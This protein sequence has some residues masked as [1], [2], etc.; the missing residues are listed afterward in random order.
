M[1]VPKSPSDNLESF[2][3][4]QMYICHRSIQ[5]ESSSCGL[6]YVLDPGFTERARWFELNVCCCKFLVVLIGILLLFLSGIRL[7][8]VT[9]S[10]TTVTLKELSYRS[11][12]QER[13]RLASAPSH[14]AAPPT[15]WEWS[16]VYWTTVTSPEATLHQWRLKVL[17]F[18]NETGLVSTWQ[19]SPG[20]FLHIWHLG[21]TAALPLTFWS[22]PVV[23]INLWVSM[24]KMST[25]AWKAG[26]TRLGLERCVRPL[27]LKTVGVRVSAATGKSR[28]RKGEEATI[29]KIN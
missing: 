27:W 21:T 7:H 10:S 2:G 5:P 22:T 24:L 23:G 15:C 17:L 25:W 28:S 9:F 19:P 13:A 12:V 26:C 11:V 16:S 6:F 1:W 14:R 18:R 8:G 3:K 20:H 4:C 29:P